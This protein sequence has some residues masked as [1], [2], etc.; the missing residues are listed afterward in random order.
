MSFL[1]Y[2]YKAPEGLPPI[3]RWSEN[4]AA[5][6]GS[7]EQVMKELSLLY[8]QL[9][10]RRGDKY[11]VGLSSQLEPY[12][13]IILTEEKQNNCFFVVLNKAAPSVMRKIMEALNLNYV[14]APE[15]DDLVDPYAYSDSETYFAK[16]EWVKNAL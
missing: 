12:L 10:W 5:P 4:H 3:N 14:S 9:Q 8:P 2:L 15:S 13:D 7:V 1:F 6:L 11:W 16:R